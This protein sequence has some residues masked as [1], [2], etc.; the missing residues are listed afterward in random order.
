MKKR[1]FMTY[2][3][4]IIGAGPA[5]ATLARVLKEGR[6]SFKI[7]LIDGQSEGQSKVCGGLISTDAQKLLA[8][9]NLALPKSV[10]EDPQIFAVETIDL[11]YGILTRYAR[12]YIN[13]DRLKFDRWLTSL[14][15]SGVDVTNGRAK[16]VRKEDDV[17]TI[18]ADT[19]DG[20]IDFRAKRLVGAD[21]A[22][23][24]VRRSFFKSKRIF[25][26]VAIQQWF[27]IEDKALPYYSC[28]FD[29]KT[30][31][32]CSWTIRKGKYFIFGGAFGQ[33][34]C[35]E[36]FD[37][38]KSRLEKFLGIPLPE[39][40]KTEACQ[41]CSPRSR[42]SFVC[43]D[44]GV[45]L[46]GE[47]AGLI[48]ASS[49]EGISSAI[50]SGKLLADSIIEGGESEKA[51]LKKYRKKSRSL[52]R[53]MYFKIPKMRILTSPVLR[54]I[55]MKSKFSAIKDYSKNSFGGK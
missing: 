52:R 17:F 48:S 4:A 5:G 31:D 28:I 13:T 22:S 8:E 49:F 1:Y 19:E 39:P 6:P 16:S 14:I 20:R 18:S 51:V 34:R 21:G 33:K 23:S 29:R 30:S 24:I 25:K 10:L 50:L 53:K 9:F 35:R 3:I 46:I 37:M 42:R 38:Q 32:S 55:I 36:S 11:D 47:A 44:E 26:Y 45:Y 7:L 41:V 27:E 43:G 15:P 40:V 12:N 2:D 54:K